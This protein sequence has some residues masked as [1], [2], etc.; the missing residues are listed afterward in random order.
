MPER[1]GHA[2]LQS[3][4]T[5]FN[6]SMPLSSPFLRRHW[7]FCLAGGL[8]LPTLLWSALAPL[9]RT[10]HERSF[11]FPAA[12]PGARHL[13]LPREVGLTLGVQDVLLIKNLD[14]Q[15][16]V[17]GPLQLL[18]G[19]QFR[20]PFEHVGVFAYACPDV[21]GGTLRVRVAPLPDPGWQRLRWRLAALAGALRSLPVVAPG[22]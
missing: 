7:L 9:P 6:P 14:R 1:A 12:A 4:A 20:L 10:S 22:A 15:P 21:P 2:V 16:H 18:P 11:I 3:R 13:A 8:L 19:E 5:P 17:L